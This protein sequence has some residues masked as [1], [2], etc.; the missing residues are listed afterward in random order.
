LVAKRDACRASLCALGLSLSAVASTTDVETVYPMARSLYLELH[1]HPE[2]SGHEEHTAARL[3]TQLRAA[4]YQV[5]EHVGGT[6]VVAVLRNGAG[7]TVMLRSELDALPVE[8]KTGLPYA[9]KVRTKDDAGNDV[10]VG[11]MCGHDLHMSALVATATLL[12]RSRDGWHGTLVLVGQPA[13]E[14]VKGA[15]AM[16]KDGLLTRSSPCTCTTTRQPA[17]WGSCPA[18]TTPTQTR[19]ASRSSARAGTAR[20]RTRPSIPS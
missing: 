8:E 11:H 18:S 4:G 20:R 6:G 15:E 2:L 12:A 1:Q 10:S 19:C 14:T 9:S 17:R 16:V 13:E 3:A 5:T 7:R